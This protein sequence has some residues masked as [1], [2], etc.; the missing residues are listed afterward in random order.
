MFFVKERKNEM[1]KF[2]QELASIMVKLFGALE[3]EFQKKHSGLSGTSA[4]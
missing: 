1:I 2:N 3:S 4:V